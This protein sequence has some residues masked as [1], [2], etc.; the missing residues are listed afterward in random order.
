MV[1]RLVTQTLRPSAINFYPIEFKGVGL[2]FIEDP[3]RENS[4]IKG[5]TIII[6][7][8]IRSSLT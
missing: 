3:N 4:S 6:G 5:D 8:K 1:S 2:E 7:T